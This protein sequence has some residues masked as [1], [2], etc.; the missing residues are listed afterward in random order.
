MTNE[1][2]KDLERMLRIFAIKNGL[3]LAQ[4]TAVAEGVVGSLKWREAVREEQAL[5]TK[6]PWQQPETD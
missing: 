6:T 2:Y 3:S 4:V 5:E 1:T